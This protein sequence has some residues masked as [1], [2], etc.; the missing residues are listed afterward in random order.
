MHDHALVTRIADLLDRHRLPPDAMTLEITEDMLMNER[1]LDLANKYGCSPGRISQ[2]RREFERDWEQFCDQD[3]SCPAGPVN[4][5]CATARRQAF[6]L[7]KG[8]P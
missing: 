7:R 6:N 1:T 3:T 4:A 5:R 2:M 8:A